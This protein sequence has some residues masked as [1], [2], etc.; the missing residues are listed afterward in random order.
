MTGMPR[1]S[2]AASPAGPPTA[3]AAEAVAALAVVRRDAR[4]RSLLVGA[5]LAGVVLTGVWLSLAWGGHAREVLD[6]V[7]ALAGVQGGQES[8]RIGRLRGPRTAMAVLVGAAFGIAGG[9]FQSVLRNPLASPDILGVS[10]GA[11]LAAAFGL[12]VLGLTGAVVGLAAFTG[13][14]VV[15]TAI[16]VLAW[17]GG[18]AGYR[19]VL[20]GVGI[21]F[22]INAGIGY[23]LTRA[24]VNDVRAA[25]V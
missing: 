3:G 6:H 10:G 16:Y 20:I 24:E 8:F 19:F 15:A 9:L 18:V 23:L 4:R 21:A 12:I 5:V 17:R 1:T 2:A 14:A 7:A 25:L 13:A 11:S 22:A